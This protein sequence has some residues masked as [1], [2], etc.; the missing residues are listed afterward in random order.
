[1][2]AGSSTAVDGLP[3]PPSRAARFKPV[4][5]ILALAWLARLAF[6]LKMPDSAR[7][8]DV[9]AWSTVADVLATGGNPYQATVFLNYPPFW[10]QLIFLIAKMSG[11]L[12]IEFFRCLQFVLIFFESAAILLTLRLIRRMAPAARAATLVVVG[13][14]LNP[15]AILQVCQHCN[16]DVIVAFWL[17]LFLLSLLRYN[18]TKDFA[19]WLCA[20]LF[21]GLGILTKTVPLI[22]VPL[23]AGGFRQAT[24]RIRFLGITLLLGPVSVGL[25]IIYVLAPADVI[26][27][28]IEYRSRS[29]YFGLS[30]L[31]HLAG[32]DGAAFVCNLAFYALLLAVLVFSAIFFW[33]RQS[34][35]DRETVLWAALLLAG[36]PALGP[37]YAPQYIYWFMPL[38]VAA[39][40]GFRGNFRL[41]LAAFG[42]IAACTYVVEYA[43]MGAYGMFLPK[44]LAL[45]NPNLAIALVPLITRIQKPAGETLASLPLFAA[46]LA[47]LTSGVRVL[48]QSLKP[49]EAKA[50]ARDPYRC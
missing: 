42:V 29:G 47:L 25:S 7:S 39:F 10:L 4:A 40:A 31:C 8:F 2:K 3:A 21:L 15:I 36:I 32:L 41:V 23:L 27:K 35:G 19:D 1:M 48:F 18:R 46:Y 17:L 9:N 44:I 38:L 28:V 50:S 45:E 13:L 22:L 49:A 24:H 12:S 33:R 16:F 43:L 37:G 26:T 5:L 30:G 6:I 11:M 14:A 34:I 20:T